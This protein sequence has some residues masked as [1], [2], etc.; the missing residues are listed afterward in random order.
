MSLKSRIISTEIVGISETII[1]D[2]FCGSTRGEGDGS[3]GWADIIDCIGNLERFSELNTALCNKRI[4]KRGYIIVRIPSGYL[5][6]IKGARLEIFKRKRMIYDIFIILVRRGESRIKR[7]YI[8][9]MY[10]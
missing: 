8:G 3:R 4:D 9:K 6:I 2:I 5:I 10:F 7:I 1:E